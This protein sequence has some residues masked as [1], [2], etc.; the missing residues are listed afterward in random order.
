[1]K[2]KRKLYAADDYK[3]NILGSGY[4]KLLNPRGNSLDLNPSDSGKNVFL[5]IADD[6]YRSQIRAG[7]N[8]IAKQIKRDRRRGI[9]NNLIPVF[10]RKQELRDNAV[11]DF[12]NRQRKSGL[13][14]VNNGRGIDVWGWDKAG[15]YGVVKSSIAYDSVSNSN[16]KPGFFDRLFKRKETNSSN[17]SQVSTKPTN[18]TTTTSTISPTNI[19]N[20]NITTPNKNKTVKV[21]RDKLNQVVGTRSNRSNINNTMTSTPNQTQTTINSPVNTTT[22]TTTKPTGG[23]TTT[24]TPNIGTRTTTSK[25]KA[26]PTPKPNIPKPKTGNWVSNTWNNMG[27][28]GKGATIGTAALA[29]GLAVKG[30]MGSKKKK[31]KEEDQY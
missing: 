4:N 3:L 29:T 12:N 16:K 18:T 9:D 19:N 6:K 24:T 30:L 5:D 14:G 8:K 20:S 21:S 17:P 31:K 22:S 13:S 15:N 10:S 11:N 23:G 25:P 2:L 7:R 26:T 27:T 28:L 1:M